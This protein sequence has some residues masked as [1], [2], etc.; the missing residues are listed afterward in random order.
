[1]TDALLCPLKLPW[2]VALVIATV[3][4]V[5][6]LL[7]HDEH[8]NGILNG[9]PPTGMWLLMAVKFLGVTPVAKVCPLWQLEQGR[10]T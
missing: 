2:A 5:V 3:V 6:V 1:M 4:N 10:V 7:W 8:S 9:A